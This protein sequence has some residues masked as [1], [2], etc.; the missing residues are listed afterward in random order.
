MRK[1][2]VVNICPRQR[3]VRINF[4]RFQQALKALPH[5]LLPAGK[6]IVI[7]LVSDRKIRKLNQLFRGNNR[8]TDVLSFRTGRQS[9][10]VIISVETAR[11]QAREYGHSLEE[12]LIYLVIHGLLH[13][14]GFT[15]YS[16]AG[17]QRMKARQDSILQKVRRSLKIK[18]N[19]HE[20]IH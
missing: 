19:K 8:P 13:L 17:Y 1:R 7:V 3:K 10:E 5:S 2:T 16:P 14:E 11:R 6:E 12:E 4:D 15:D 18:A 20:I 9:G